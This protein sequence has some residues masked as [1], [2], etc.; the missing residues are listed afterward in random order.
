MEEASCLVIPTGAKRSGG[1]CGF[2]FP[3]PLP[4]ICRCTL[5]SC[6]AGVQ[7]NIDA[8]HCGKARKGMAVLIVLF[9]SL[10]LY[11]G[12]G[13]LGV[14]ALQTWLVCARLALATMFVFTAIAHFASPR[15]DL[16]AM[17]PPSVSPAR[18]VGNDHRSAGIRRRHRAVAGSHPPVGGLGIDPAAAG[19]ASGECERRAAWCHFA[20]T[21]SHSA[22]DPHSPASP[23]HRVGVVGA[24]VG[25][26]IGS[27]HLA[28]G[29]W[30]LALRFWLLACGIPTRGYSASLSHKSR[31]SELSNALN[32][33][34][35]TTQI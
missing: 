10:L 12:L 34:W 17:V 16:I 20:R 13:A 25:S 7:A 18:S 35:D 8:K 22:V 19:D 23:V 15:Q 26:G 3:Q 4:H 30:P 1:I 11:R 21:C 33:I 14:A 31:S 27:W 32:Q 9:G 6:V 5:P 29:S 24:A 28:L 2:L